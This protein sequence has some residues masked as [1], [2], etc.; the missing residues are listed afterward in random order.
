M[1]ESLTRTF[2]LSMCRLHIFPAEKIPKTLGT[3][4]ILAGPSYA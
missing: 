2:K 4:R 1:S 3:L